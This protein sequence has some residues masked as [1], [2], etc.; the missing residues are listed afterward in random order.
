M[1]KLGRHKKPKAT[2]EEI[3]ED[4][5][6]S[7]PLETEKTSKEKQEDSERKKEKDIPEIVED[8]DEW[9]EKKEPIKSSLLKKKI[10]TGTFKNKG[11]TEKKIADFIFSTVKSGMSTGFDQKFM[12]KNS[13]KLK[14]ASNEGLKI[15]KKQLVKL[16]KMARRRT[17]EVI[18]KIEERIAIL[19]EKYAK[20]FGYEPGAITKMAIKLLEELEHLALEGITYIVELLEEQL[21]IMNEKFQTKIKNSQSKVSKP[22][23]SS[24]KIQTE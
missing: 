23:S 4:D 21:T 20:K 17:E 2:K 14:K 10:K 1:M 12:E 7:P 8:S 13:G 6:E 9:D 16:D 15:A 24:K 19:D 11:T 5:F 3:G 18:D 22:S